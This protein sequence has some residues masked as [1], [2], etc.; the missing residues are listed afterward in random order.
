MKSNECPQ[1][2]LPGPC[3]C[4]TESRLNAVD[5]AAFTLN[6]SNLAAHLDS[7]VKNT[8]AV[9]EPLELTGEEQYV[10]IRR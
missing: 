2:C 7:F 4:R 9:L 8:P 5:E 1:N 3:A 10:H 6:L